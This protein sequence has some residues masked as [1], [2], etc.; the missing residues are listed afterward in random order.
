MKFRRDEYAIPEQACPHN[1]KFHVAYLYNDRGQLL[2]SKMN[3][4]ASR[5]R[6]AG[7]SD[8]TMHAERAVLQAL[9][10]FT[11]LRGATM[12]VVRYGACGDLLPSKPCEECASHLTKAMR[13]YGLRRVY[14][15]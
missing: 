4:V 12:V 3:R 7:C 8:Y 13:L 5:S 6:G 14:Y 11:K 9:G 15:S 2:C 1:T 10:D